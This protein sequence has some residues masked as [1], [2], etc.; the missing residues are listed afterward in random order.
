MLKIFSQFA[1]SEIYVLNYRKV[2]IGNGLGYTMK[3]ICKVSRSEVFAVVDDADVLGRQKIR[4]IKW[5][6]QGFF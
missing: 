5:G 1:G 3:P 6:F 4:V 2:I